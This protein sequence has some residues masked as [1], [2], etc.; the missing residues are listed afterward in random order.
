[1]DQATIPSPE[2]IRERAAEIVAGPDYRIDSGKTD[3]GWVFDLMLELLE[4]ILLPFRWVFHLTEGLPSFLRWMIVIALAVI[5]V[6]LVA[7]IIYSIAIAVRSPKTSGAASWDERRRTVSPSDLERL[8]D[9]AAQQADHITAI[10]YL[11]RAGVARVELADKKPNRPGT[12]NRELLRRF[13]NRPALL[14]AFSRFVD[15]IDHKWYGDENCSEAD[16]LACREAHEKI[17]QNIK[18]TVN[19]V[20]T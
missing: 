20:G 4:W 15:T 19:A 10:R 13:R 12:T 11:F 6:L 1:M 16:Y 18:E 14:Q 8:A 3:S 17:R 5:V 7:H 9:E 2:R